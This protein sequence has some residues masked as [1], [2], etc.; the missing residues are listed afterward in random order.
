MP[1]LVYVT[2]RFTFS[3]AH[4]YW[5]PEWSPEMNRERF[6]PLAEIH[7]HTYGLEVTIRGPVDGATGM[8]MDLAELKRLVEGE[9]VPRLDHRYLNDDREFS[10][11]LP[12]TENLARLIWRL[13]APKLG[14]D[15]LWRV[16]LA[17]DATFWVDYHGPWR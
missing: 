12:T 9:A 5:R 15:R 1:E 17:E 6:G 7:G 14:E 11:E 10:A 13:L 2:R 16:R 4:R 3:A 8:V